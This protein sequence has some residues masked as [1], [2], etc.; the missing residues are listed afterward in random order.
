MNFA[1]NSTAALK[2]V[3]SVLSSSNTSSATFVI[4][5]TRNGIMDTITLNNLPPAYFTYNPI[6][7]DTIV[8]ASNGAKVGYIAYQS[9][10]IWDGSSSTVL[11]NA[12]TAFA[13]SSITDLVIDLRYNG[14][15]YVVTS[16]NFANLA[17]PSSANGKTMFTEYYNDTMTSGNATLL[18][19]QGY[20]VSA[21]Y[22]SASNNTY[23]FSKM[24][25]V[26]SLTRII[27][28]VSNNTASAAE[29]LINNLKPYLNVIL[30]GTQWQ[31]GSGNNTYGKPV[32]FFPINIG[33][34]VYYFPEFA[35]GNATDPAG[36]ATYYNGIAVNNASTDDARYN[37]GNPKETAFAQALYYIVNGSYNNNYNAGHISN[38]R[39]INTL[40]LKNTFKQSSYFNGM[41][42]NPV[43]RR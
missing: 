6:F 27:F 4:Q 5:Q 18:A 35:S 24:G 16:Q 42:H 26:G 12:F 14:G 19:K 31:S 21:S 43:N 39:S 11:Q 32:G 9:F 41:I 3:N 34:Y 33:K 2:V 13:N 15:G 28:L 25:S 37:F 23:K 10:T 22:W 36:G 20:P 40:S 8:T 30:I 38:L 1:T 7:K 17:A 29:L